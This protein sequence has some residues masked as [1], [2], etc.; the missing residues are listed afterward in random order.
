MYDS[1]TTAVLFVLLVPGVLVTLPPGMSGIIPVIVH[2]IVFWAVQ[3][4]LSQYLPWWGVWAIAAVVIAGKMWMTRSA[5]PP[6][7]Y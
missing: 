1:I 7:Y 4:Y 5:A 6:A 2:A 3:T